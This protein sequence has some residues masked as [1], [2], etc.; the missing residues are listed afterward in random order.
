M[1]K[2]DLIQL[3]VTGILAIVLIFV[4]SSAFKKKPGALGNSKNTLPK[5]SDSAMVS[6]NQVKK[7][8]S[9]GLYHLL[10]Q[11]ADSLEL[12]RD[13]FTAAPITSEKALS[14]EVDLTGIL[15]DKDKPLAII[16]GDIIKKG[17][18][19]GSKTIIE[20]KRD[21]VILSDGSALYEIKLKR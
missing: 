8:E 18:R 4:L 15:W 20:I 21:R 9:Q 13:P 3:G 16:N 1:P 2:K 19:L 6:A 11:Q 17:E 7:S 10:E 5:A 12:K 14:G